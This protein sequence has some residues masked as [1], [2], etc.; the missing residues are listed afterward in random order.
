VHL[1]VGCEVPGD[2]E[3][4][5]IQ[6]VMIFPEDLCKNFVALSWDMKNMGWHSGDGGEKNL[7][8]QWINGVL[9]EILAL[10]RKLIRT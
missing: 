9:E 5:K 4:L 3:A 6:C 8:K 7:D 10:N 1:H 2:T